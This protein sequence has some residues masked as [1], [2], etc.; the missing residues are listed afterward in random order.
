MK[1][2]NPNLIELSIHSR[3]NNA[4]SLFEK[5]ILIMNTKSKL[6]SKQRQDVAIVS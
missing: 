1:K 3:L 6:Q 2:K 4:E 5:T